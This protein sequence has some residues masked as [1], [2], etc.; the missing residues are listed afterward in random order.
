MNES[1]LSRL[2]EIV[3]SA[4]P[5]TRELTY[6][7][8]VA[9]WPAGSPRPDP[10]Q[11]AG[12][13]DGRLV[14]P[15]STLRE[16]RDG[17][18][19][20]DARRS[21][22]Q[23]VVIDR[24]YA[25]DRLHGRCPVRAAAEGCRTR[26]DALSIIRAAWPVRSHAE[27][28]GPARSAVEWSG[29]SPVEGRLLFVDIETTGLNGGAGMFAFLI[30]C[31][32]FDGDTFRTR[33]LFLPSFSDEHR[34]LS[35]IAGLVGEAGAIVTFNGRTFDVPVMEM[36]YLFHRR[37]SPFGELPH[38]DMLHPAR[39]LWKRRHVDSD[40]HADGL[41]GHPQ[42]CSLSALERGVLGF[43]R[44]DDVPGFEIPGRY[45]QY[46]RTSDTRPLEPVLE[47]NRLDLL[48]L[49]VLTSVV[50]RLVAEG[51]DAA[52]DA[53]ECLELGRLFERAGQV[54]RG[55]ACYRRAV[56]WAGPTDELDQ[57]EALVAL[58]LA[59]R[60]ERRYGEAAELC[61]RVLTLRSCPPVFTRHALHILAVHHEHRSR[62]LHRARS[63]ALRSLD[64]AEP[65][66]RH[67]VTHRI[68][69]IDRKLLA[70]M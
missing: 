39:R 54:D 58:A 51:A 32:F 62:D 61:E 26:H 5:A 13:L 17:P 41:D 14:R 15:A 12:L 67:R 16:P 24:E 64:Q 69:R 25:S 4:R 45:F 10:E 1:R 2:R 6:E 36:R 63:F 37:E 35:E 29:P 34:L 18:G 3:R 33:Q 28:I 30:G 49:A 7:P 40:W 46:L 42:S 44:V 70:E 57:A 65:A 60:G 50:L 22:G 55:T 68:A 47:H 11:I 59:F 66:R 21:P 53:R 8:N 52:A 31:G 9:G 27:T 48:S 38:I 20:V 56:E 19:P 43:E 23:A